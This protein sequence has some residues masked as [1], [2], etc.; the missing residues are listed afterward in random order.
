[1]ARSM[2]AAAVMLVLLPLWSVAGLEGRAQ[3]DGWLSLRGGVGLADNLGIDVGTDSFASK[4]LP[5]TSLGVGAFFSLGLIE[6]GA[7][8]E[9]ASAAGTPAVA[10]NERL[11]GQVRLAAALRWLVM[12][13]DWGG[14]FMGLAGGVSMIRFS[15]FVRFELGRS[16]S[17]GLEDVDRHRAAFLLEAEFGMLFNV[18]DSTRLLFALGAHTSNGELDV[19]TTSRNFFATQLQF[20]VGVEWRP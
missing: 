12:G 13:D 5:S 2:S 6:L 15:D 20:H 16:A 14:L 17:V 3:A 4:D 8:F 10:A 11:F 19:G 18:E 7:T 9:V 1:M